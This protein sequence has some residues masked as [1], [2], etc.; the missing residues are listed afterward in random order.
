MPNCKSISCADC[1]ALRTSAFSQLSLDLCD[2]LHKIKRKKS[3]LR[4]EVIFKEGETFD[5]FHC[6]QSGSVKV[7][8]GCSQARQTFLRL[9]AP[10]DLLGVERLNPRLPRSRSA[11]AI[12]D[13]R[14]CLFSWHDLS[15]ELNLHLPLF[16]GIIDYLA[17]EILTLEEMVQCLATKSVRERLAFVLNF[18][19]LKF[20]RACEY[21]SLIDVDIS[22]SDLAVMAGTST[23]SA[24]RNLSDFEEEG[25]LEIVRRR[26]YLKSRAALQKISGLS[27]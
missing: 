10:G 4:G 15:A 9:K 27:N 13:T 24:V 14:T 21:G 2:S 26:I 1:P 23:E 20:G 22:R 12:A 3:Y 7:F 8:G 19:D 17:A 25:V 6:I 5:G 16:L 18:L 11:L